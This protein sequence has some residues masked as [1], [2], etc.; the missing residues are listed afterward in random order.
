MAEFEDFSSNT[1]VITATD[2]DKIKIKSGEAATTENF[3]RSVVDSI[4][5]DIK[6]EAAMTYMARSSSLFTTNNTRFLSHCEG[7]GIDVIGLQAPELTTK[8]EDVFLD[9]STFIGAAWPQR[10]ATNMM[11]YGSADSALKTLTGWTVNVTDGLKANVTA[12]AETYL[13]VSTMDIY[14]DIV[15]GDVTI[16]SPVIPLT[17]IEN[18]LNKVSGGFTLTTSSNM[19]STATEVQYRFKILASDQ[20]TQVASHDTSIIKGSYDGV[21]GIEN[22]DVPS[23][24]KYFQVQ[25]TVRFKNSDSRALFTFKNVMVQAGGILSPYTTTTRQ[26]CT[27]E[28]KNIIQPSLG[29]ISLLNWSIYKPYSLATHAGPIGP[30]F[31]SMGNVKIG[32]VHR[33][34]DGTNLVFSLYIYD[35]GNVTYSDEFTVPNQYLGEYL[36]NCLRIRPQEEN[37]EKSIVEYAIIAGPEIYSAQLLIDTSKVTKGDIIL[38]T[39]RINA[40]YF[41]GPVT[42]VRYDQEWINDIELYIIS[43]AKKAFSFKKSNDLGAADAGESVQDVLDKVGVNLILNPTARLAYIG[44]NDYNKEFFSPVH[45]DTYAGNCFLWVGTPAEESRVYS[46]TIGIK[47]SQLY[48]F[49]AVMYSQEGSSGEAGIGITWY[50][51]EGAEISTT[52]TNITHVYQPKYVSTAAVAPADAVSAKV[53]MYA[54]P[55]LNTLR[56]TWSKLKFEMGDATLFSDDSGAGYALYY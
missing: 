43:L 39:D 30:A 14:D 24:G 11:S 22:I 23:S 34:K 55:N 31:I 1:P 50:N 54:M 38:G 4:N 2:Y 12:A 46:D 47:P 19:V 56:L 15:P 27:C 6:M 8:P 17:G 37:P 28:Y 13:Q 45:N 25:M 49:R 16:T 35:D 44:W 3:N 32:G 36:L 18:A 48:T 7:Q 40:D 5:R 41:N 29:N 42:E 10:A 33:S 9:D 52:K 53:F 26:Q 51:T 21:V 20:V